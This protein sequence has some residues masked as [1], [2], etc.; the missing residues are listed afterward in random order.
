MMLRVSVVMVAE[1]C[2]T[3]QERRERERERGFERERSFGEREKDKQTYLHVTVQP[4]HSAIV[5]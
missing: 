4:Y 5:N 2:L 3:L 1:V